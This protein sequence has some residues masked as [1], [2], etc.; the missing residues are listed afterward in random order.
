MKI[1]K[2]ILFLLSFALSTS[3]QTAINKLKHEP[4]I[5]QKAI[6]PISNEKRSCPI[7]P[8]FGCPSCAG[9]FTGPSGQTGQTGQ[10]GIICPTGSNIIPAQFPCIATLIANIT[11]VNAECLEVRDNLIIFGN[12]N[13]K[14]DLQIEEDLHVIGDTCIE[15]DLAVNEDTTI[16][17]NQ[18]IV[19]GLTVNNGATI[20]G[21]LVENGD[22][23]INGNLIISGSKTVDQNVTVG[24]TATINGLV[25]ATGSLSVFNGE[26]IFSGGLQVFNTGCTGCT[27][28]QISGNVCVNGDETVTGDKL[29]QGE[30]TVDELATFNAVTIGVSGVTGS[31]FITNNT[32]V[33][34]ND[35][36]I[37]A[38]DEII[39]S[40]SLILDTG[41]ILVG[42]S[43]TFQG[44]ITANDGAVV[45]GGL[46]VNGG[47][48]IA[49]GD[50]NVTLGNASI[51]GALTV[52]GSIT[53]G[54]AIFSDLMITSDVNSLC[55]TGPAAL[56]VNG[57]VGIAKDLWLGGSQ[58]FSNVVTEGG[59][60]SAFNY[61]EE[62]CFSTSFVFGGLPTTPPQSVLI[63]IVRVGN[64]VN[65]MIPPVII[66]NPGI[67][68]DVI[69]SF[70]PLPPRF[71]PFTTIRGASSTIIYNDPTFG[72][73]GELGEYDVS[74]AG[75]ITFGLSRS[76]IGPQPIR[77][78]DYVILDANT[79]TYNLGGCERTCKLPACG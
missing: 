10:T 73:I 33:M 59:I 7:C 17:G 44:P 13:I 5:T 77:S 71:R 72:V 75:I 76:S 25:T 2:V 20:S 40:G 23:T 19:G 61:Y 62:A 29:V 69:R 1:R 15:E 45:L 24:A 35:L 52:N 49:L 43:T 9:S 50:F 47:S 42:G 22:Q 68:I 65:L 36:T 30:L 41:N 38:G 6:G 4:I 32:V 51:A 60:P 28:A 26:V 67:H 21:S 66:N 11:S 16:D 56:I 58:Y 8:N 74:P 46:M 63:K 78:L 64:I 53:G 18:V 48:T 34:N 27:G 57:G 3:R 70:T 37:E 14:E 31:T 39:K 79:I 55:P 12:G 54:A